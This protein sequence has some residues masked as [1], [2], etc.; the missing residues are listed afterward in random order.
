M[1]IADFKA[2]GFK[3]QFQYKSFVP[4]LINHD[5][6]M[7]NSRVST[8]LSQADIKLGELNAFSELIP[9][10]NFFIMMHIYK[11]ATSSNRIEGTQTNIEEVL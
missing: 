5:W 6:Q 7:S 10:V 2:G 9:D 3:E 4:T 11:E 1:D 8:L